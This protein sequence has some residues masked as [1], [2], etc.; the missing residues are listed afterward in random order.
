MLRDL[1]LICFQFIGFVGFMS[2]VILVIRDGWGY[3]K[4]TDQNGILNSNIPVTNKLM[5]DYPNTLLHCSGLS[6][7]LP[8]GFQGN[9]EVGHMTIGSGRILF[10][11]LVKIDASIEDK[12]FFKNEAF[13]GAI[14]NAKKNN[15]TLHLIGLFQVEG[16]HAH[17]NH[18][19]ALLDLCKKENF[20]NVK[21]H[22]ITDGRDAP[23]TDSLKHV[24]TVEDK[25]K[26][27]GFGEIATISGRF[28][29]MDRDKRW[30]RTRQAYDCIVNGETKIEFTDAT[31]AIQKSHAEEVNDEFIVPMRKSN[32]SGINENDSI[33]FFNFR[34][35]RTRQLTQAI[36]EDKFEGWERKPLNVY[37]AAMTQFYTPMN[38]KVA[39]KDISLDNL[40][41]K[42]IADAGKKQLR[43]SETEKYA[44]V[45]FFFNGQQEAPNV[46]EER[47]LVPS[48]KVATYDLK[49]EMSVYEVSEKLVSEIKK[50][51]K[52]FIVTNLVNGDMVGHTGKMPAIKRAIEAVDECVGKIVEAG[53]ANGYTILIF[54]DHGNAE[55]KTAMWATSHTLNDVPFILVSNEEKLRKAKLKSGKSLEDI[56]PTVLDIMGILKPKEMTGESIIQN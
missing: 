18:L 13:I 1:N 56:A 10:Q 6:V 36:V 3:R 44:H 11:S 14:N 42:V 4:E 24:K 22:A 37:Y 19:L 21:I 48:P 31:S 55:D 28:Y 32:Y 25:L 54:A 38:A 7:G 20:T 8:K 15:S 34:T 40:L 39:F 17:I 27:L 50:A 26:S 16:V 46:N 51:D 9:S 5:A 53:L 49:P 47:I 12:S 29:A 45:T 2:K 35:D 41:G 30:E 33:I 52:D 43:I 23:V